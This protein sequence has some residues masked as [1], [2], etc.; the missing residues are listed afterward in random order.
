MVY[1]LVD[2]YGGA[3]AVMTGNRSA[4]EGRDQSVA[5]AAALLVWVALIANRTYC[6]HGTQHRRAR[7]TPVGQTATSNCNYSSSS[8]AGTAGCARTMH[9]FAGK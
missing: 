6:E 3:S 5:A 1:E 8:T 7:Q 2:T 4:P 9:V